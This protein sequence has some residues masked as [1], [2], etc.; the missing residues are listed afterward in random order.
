MY[1]SYDYYIITGMASGGSDLVQDTLS[2][3]IC[4]ERFDCSNHLPKILPC[5][6]TFCTSCIDSLMDKSLYVGAFNCPVC[7]GEVTGSNEV[8]TNLAVKDIV[9]AVITKEKA[10]L[11]CP[12]HPAKE[13]QLV[14]TDCCQP[15]CAVCVQGVIKGE[16][17]EH[18]I[19]DVDDAKVK[20]KDRLTMAVKTKCAIL[21]NATLAKMEK[22]NIE[23]T[24]QEKELNAI[25]YMITKALNKWKKTQLQKAQQA[26]DK[27]LEN[28]K[29]QQELWKEK[30]GM[31]DLQTMMSHLIAASEEAESEESLATDVSL[32]KINLDELQNKLD[33]LCNTIQKLITSNATLPSPSPPVTPSSPK[34]SGENHISW[35]FII[36]LC[37]C[38]VPLKDPSKRPY[39]PQCVKNVANMYNHNRNSQFLRVV[40]DKR[41]EQDRLLCKTDDFI[42]GFDCSENKRNTVNGLWD[43][44]VIQYVEH[45]DKAKNILHD[46]KYTTKIRNAFERWQTIT[47]HNLRN[48]IPELWWEIQK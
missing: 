9:E 2:C 6:H 44:R 33:S 42:F 47:L 3:G 38:S 22:L 28:N 19:D 35:D 12:K 45:L 23:L 11:F 21:E 18:S 36:H 48:G 7:R 13:C 8:H 43:S 32:P 1:V 24:Q 4:L 46:P 25:V 34:V 16:H 10:K 37:S 15:L 14:C 30:L 29:A 39:I 20:I 40:H 17:K 41:N 27:E 5:Q 26:T 31:S